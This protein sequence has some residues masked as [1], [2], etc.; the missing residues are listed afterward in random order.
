MTRQQTISMSTLGVDIR[1]GESAFGRRRTPA[2][3]CRA[4]NS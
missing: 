1:L 2:M 3:Q 4:T